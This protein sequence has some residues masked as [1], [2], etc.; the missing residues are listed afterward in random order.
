MADDQS[1]RIRFYKTHIYVDSFIN[2][3]ECVCFD[4]R[5]ASACQSPKIVWE[6]PRKFFHDDNMI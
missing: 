2:R 3:Y 6:L 1:Q 4:D 5:S